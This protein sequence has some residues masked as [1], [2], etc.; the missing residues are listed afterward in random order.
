M[1]KAI[2]TDNG[3]SLKIK[4]YEDGQH[5][6]KIKLPISED[7]L[8]SRQLRL[9]A[10]LVEQIEDNKVEKKGFVREVKKH[11]PRYL[12]ANIIKT[13]FQSATVLIALKLGIS[14]IK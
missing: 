14:W 4:S 3:S 9:I 2:V 13:I 5:Y 8:N 10:E 11:M 12:I 6:I 7:G 1:S